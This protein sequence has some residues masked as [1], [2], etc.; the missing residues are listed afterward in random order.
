MNLSQSP[1]KHGS[2]AVG[3]PLL[4][5]GLGLLVCKMSPQG[6]CISWL[7]ASGDHSAATPDSSMGL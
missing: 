2:G 5:L 4:S 3:K 7:F 6:L 1:E